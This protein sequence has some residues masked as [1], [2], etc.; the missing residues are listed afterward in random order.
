MSRRDLITVSVENGHYEVN[1]YI[2]NETY[3]SVKAEPKNE[4]LNGVD[5]IRIVSM[6]LNRYERKIP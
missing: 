1:D 2:K 4:N 3:V 5:V 6:L